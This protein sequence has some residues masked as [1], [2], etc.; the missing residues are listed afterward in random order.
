MIR[1]L[2][3]LCLGA[4]LGVAGYRKVTARVNAVLHP[5]RAAAAFARDVREGMHLY[6]A[7]HDGQAPRL[8]Y[9]GPASNGGK[10][11]EPGRMSRHRAT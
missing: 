5:E 10:S 2:F 6:R 7:G 3:W 11:S 4:V 8:E 1:R 9:P